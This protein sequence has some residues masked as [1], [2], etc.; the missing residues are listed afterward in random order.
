MKTLCK[1]NL[2]Q[3]VTLL[4]IQHKRYFNYPCPR[5][6]RELMQM[7]LIEKEDRDKIKDIWIEYHK[8]K[9]KTFGAIIDGEAMHQIIKK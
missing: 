8:S 5:K 2:I 7:S 3:N 1:N 4:N 6:L 9:P